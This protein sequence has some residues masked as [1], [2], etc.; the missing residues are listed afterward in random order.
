MSPR[1][2]SDHERRKLFSRMEWIF[3]WAPPLLA[4]FVGVFGGAFVAWLLR[5]DGTTY[6]Q[7]WIGATGLL[8]GGTALLY[9]IHYWWT[10][11]R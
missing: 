7:R 2:V 10:H 1:R 8:L 5:I 9:G 6:M 3:V 4:V 11:R